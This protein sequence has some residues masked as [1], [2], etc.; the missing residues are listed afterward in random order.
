MR[1]L[2]ISARLV[3]GS[4]ALL[5]AASLSL[6]SATTADAAA[7]RDE[8]RQATNA[9]S[10]SPLTAAAKAA[11]KARFGA[12]A[13]YQES[14]QAY[15]TPER[16]AAAVPIEEDKGFQ[17]S[18]AKY[19]A[20]Q[21]ALH[22]AG[23]KP[24]T[25]DGPARSVDGA[26]S[27]VFAGTAEAAYNPNAPY[28]TPTAYTQ[29]KVFF[30]KAGGGNYACSGTIVNS[31]GKDSVWTAGHCVHGGSGGSWHYNWTFVPAYDDDLANPR[32][33][34]TWSAAYLSS[35]SAWTGSSDYSQDIG[36]ATMNTNF[37]GWHIV[38]Y[39]G[40]Q[41]ITVNRGK[42]GVY[43]YAFGY[44]AEWPFDGGNL[45]RCQGST[46][47]EWDYWFTWS[48]TVKIPCDMTRGS[49]GG[50]WLNGYDGSWGW[51]N[52]V[53]SRIDRIVGPTIMLSPYFDDDAWSLYNYTRYN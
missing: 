37:G 7:P 29:G 49:S 28:Y 13:S 33:Y 14:L 17:E 52:G 16:M 15:W 9:S 3:Y 47:P 50:G 30:T 51:L 24:V 53:N 21:K 12:D 5:A 48:Q 11:G 31:E 39:F 35:R 2:S 19:A 32:P 22:K 46:S 40:G 18:A 26:A 4:T 43:E 6:G 34:G 10:T 27:K 45:Y 1:L 20:E 41:G 36:V 8:G 25:N 42:S 38:D 23:K 44:P